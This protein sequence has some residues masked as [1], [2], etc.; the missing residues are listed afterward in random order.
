M[1]PAFTVSRRASDFAG[2]I[3]LPSL[4]TLLLIAA[5]GTRSL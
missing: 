1:F 5:T 3:D 2:A 4:P